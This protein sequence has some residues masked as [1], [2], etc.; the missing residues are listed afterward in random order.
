MSPFGQP[1]HPHGE[2]ELTLGRKPISAQ[3]P[4]V[5]AVRRP[6]Q[7]RQPKSQFGKSRPS[8]ESRELPF[9]PV[10]RRGLGLGAGLHPERFP[11]ELL[12]SSQQRVTSCQAGHDS[13]GLS[14]SDARQLARSTMR[15]RSAF[16]PSPAS[17]MEEE[18]NDQ[19][20]DEDEDEDASNFEPLPPLPLRAVL[21]SLPIGHRAAVE[22]KG[23]QR[24]SRLEL[25]WALEERQRI[26]PRS[27]PFRMH[28][29]A[30]AHSPSNAAA[31]GRHRRPHI[32]RRF[33]VAMRRR[34]GRMDAVHQSVGFLPHGASPLSS[35]PAR[36]L[37]ACPNPR[38]GGAVGGPPVA[39]GAA[40]HVAGPRT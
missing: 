38:A 15:N 25:Q 14:Q 33:S 30:S 7:R 36:R 13:M 24:K 21:P 19:A 4:V 17:S 22:F 6:K 26:A 40:E 28:A 35:T 9:P 5:A 2:V 23:V 1:F 32:R 27:L 18:P 3:P 37:T 12:R 29:L 11:R 34:C 20:L 8:T 16:I 10:L 39:A 31:A